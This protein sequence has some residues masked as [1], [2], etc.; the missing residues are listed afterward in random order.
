MRDSRQNDFC[1]PNGALA[2]QG[3]RELATEIN[4]A[5]SRDYALKIVTRDVH[6]ADH[7]SFATQHPGAK[8]FSSTHTIANPDNPQE[9]QTTTLWPPHCV[10]GTEGCELI[11][12]LN[13]WKAHHIIDKGQDKRVESYSAFGPPFRSPAVAMTG[14]AELLK[15]HAI[16]AVDVV[17]LALDYCVKHTAID[18]AKLG[19]K[20]AVLM[21]CSRAVD[22]SDMNLA[23]VWRDLERHG[24]LPALIKPN[25]ALEQCRLNEYWNRVL[26]I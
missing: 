2:V 5:L 9:T 18:A 19:F 1:G 25:S 12:E 3:G 24:V 26:S 4:T 10:Q 20:T 16:T 22:Q 17:G 6:P 23:T 14:L 13:Q 7:I 21:N 8:P 11:P 15:E